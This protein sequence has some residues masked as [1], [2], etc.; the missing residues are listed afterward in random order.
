[1]D[2]LKTLQ[3]ASEKSQA[4]LVEAEIALAEASARAVG[5]REAYSRLETAVAVLSGEP[6]PAATQNGAARTQIGNEAKQETRET[7]QQNNLV[8]AQAETSDQT[9]ERQAMADLSPEEFEAQRKR[10][11]RQRQKEEDANNPMAHVKCSG[12]GVAGK[13]SQQI[14]QA[15]SGAPVSMLICGGCNNQ[16]MT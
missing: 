3:E 9:P 11:A 4:E 13:L 10:K 15:P 1:M 14:I 2:A 16:I 12:C 8:D 7:V 5:A 6:P